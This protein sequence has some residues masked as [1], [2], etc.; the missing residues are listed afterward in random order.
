MNGYKLLIAY[1]AV[2]AALNRVDGYST[3]PPATTTVCQQMA[4]SSLPTNH[5]D[6]QSGDGGYRLQISPPMA[7]ATNGFT[8]ETGT[9]YTSKYYL[10]RLLTDDS[11]TCTVQFN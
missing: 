6:P 9:A 10:Y 1:L 11:Y 8:Y 4:P 5:G 3:G 7:T 2:C